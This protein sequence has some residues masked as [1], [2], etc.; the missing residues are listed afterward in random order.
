MAQHRPRKTTTVL[1]GPWPRQLHERLPQLL[2][3]QRERLTG[4]DRQRRSALLRR[5]R[6]VHR[7]RGRKERLRLCQ[8]VNTS[9]CIYYTLI[10]IQISNK[11]AIAA[12]LFASNGAIE[13]PA[14]IIHPTSNVTGPIASRQD[15]SH[16]HHVILDPSRR[17]FL[18]PDLG[19]D[20]I[21]VFK[22]HT[23]PSRRLLNWSP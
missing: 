6:R 10:P 5:C 11:S 20:L 14:Q 22:Y 19:A 9:S 15:D 12:F 7:S 3:H 16:A 21:R 13:P 4:K 17:F 1:P 18:V 8:L 23:I 2:P